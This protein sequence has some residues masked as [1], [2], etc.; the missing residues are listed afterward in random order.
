MKDKNNFLI[1]DIENLSDFEDDIRL[2]D[3][4]QNIIYYNEDY[5]KDLPIAPV[6]D[7][8]QEM[9]FSINSDKIEENLTKLINKEES[10]ADRYYSVRSSPIFDQKEYVG[11]VEI[12]KDI[13]SRRQLERSINRQMGDVESDLDFARVIQSKMLPAKGVYDNIILDYVYRPSHHLSGDVFDMRYIDEDHLGIYMVDVA[14]HGIAASMMTVFIRQSMQVI[15]EK[16]KSPSE[17]LVSMQEKFQELEL[18]ANRYFTMFCGVYSIK[19]QVF[20]YANAGHNSIPFLFN[21][22][23]LQMLSST[24]LPILSFDH[25]YDFIEK[26]IRVKPKDKLL[27]YTDGLTEARNSKQEEFG[28]DTIKEA[29][30][31]NPDDLLS[32][33]ENKFDEFT[34]LP[35]KDDFA[36]LL[37]EIK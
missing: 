23:K 34:D 8:P 9:M 36:I 15:F 20:S 13:T 35:Q 37:L 7:Q 27:F 19:D 2:I 25:D 10:S 18:E 29:I 3:K 21:E 11:R 22:N 33:I 4:D 16:H 24:G 30:L 5:L 26:H 1:K 14:G 32:H 28:E 31:E 17:I 6:I 12:Y